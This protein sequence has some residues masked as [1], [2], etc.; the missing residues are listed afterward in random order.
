M[1][2]SYTLYIEFLIDLE[3]VTDVSHVRSLAG[4]WQTCAGLGGAVP[5]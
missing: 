2:T 4:A 5:L 3:M 1:Y